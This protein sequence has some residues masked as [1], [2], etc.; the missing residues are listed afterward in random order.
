MLDSIDVSITIDT[1]F[2]IGGAFADP[3]NRRPI[4]IENVDCPA[5]G[6]ENGLPFLLDVFQANAIRATFFIET[7]QTIWFGDEPMGGAAQ[8]IAAAG[9][10]AQLHLHPVWSWFADPGWKD[11][12]KRETPVDNCATLDEDDLA[13]MIASG[14]ATFERWGLARP[15]AFRTGG[16]NASLSVYRAMRRNG[17]RLGSNVGLGYAAPCEP[18][19]RRASG[20][21]EVEGVIE[22]PVFTY[23]SIAPSGRWTPRLLTITSTSFEETRALLEQAHREQ[24]G[25]VVILTH[26]FEFVKAAPAGRPGVRSNRINRNR[27]EKLAAYLN[28]NADRYRATTF[29]EGAAGRW[30][31]ERARLGATPA[32]L[33]A[34]RLSSATRILSNRLN[35]MIPA[36]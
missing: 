20:L 10:D 8:R 17:L 14:I 28:R 25:P 18:E 26:P 4:G 19:L 16:L 1:E 33:R 31:P 11:R 36:L 9:Q 7:M 13:D 2:S 30:T 24:A 34:P 32:D 29:A 27:L 6:V 3:E 12:L 21:I 23:Q 22:A 5:D 35:D 15:V